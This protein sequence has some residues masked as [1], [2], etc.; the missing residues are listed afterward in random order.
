MEKMLVVYKISFSQTNK[1]Y[2]GITNDFGKRKKK[3]IQN[4]K[5]NK[6]GELYEAIR[7]YGDPIFEIIKECEDLDDLFESEKKYIQEYNSYD[8]GYNMTKG[9]Q[10]SFGSK[11]P[12]SKEWKESHSNKMKGRL[13]P[14]YGVQFDDEM[15]KRHSS[16][17]KDYY[18]NNPN[19]KAWGNKSAQ[20]LIWITNGKECKKIKK[21]T[22]I[23]AGFVKGRKLPT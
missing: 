20:G 2:V 4:A 16:L 17:L 6:H 10:G 7:L 1:C 12:K 21:Y 22:D 8:N 14:R 5:A 11:R 3:H 15:K 19:K 13:N 18:K 23:P 9:G